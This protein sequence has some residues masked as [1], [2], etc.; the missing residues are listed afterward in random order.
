MN[1]ETEY[2]RSVPLRLQSCAC[3]VDVTDHFG[4]RFLLVTPPPLAFS[5]GAASY[6][7]H[8]NRTTLRGYQCWVNEEKE[9]W[10]SSAKVRAVDG[11]VARRLWGV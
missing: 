11:T 10:K 3:G 8:V 9:M 7:T 1:L 2:P 5:I 4:R 6:L